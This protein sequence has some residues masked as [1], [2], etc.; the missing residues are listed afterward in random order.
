MTT[1][2]R[3][4]EYLSI[5]GFAI[6]LLVPSLDVVLKYFGLKG[7]AGY[8]VFGFTGLFLSYKFVWPLFRKLTEKQAIVL[9]ALTFAV[10]I[11]VV[12]YVYPIANSGGFG[13][14]SD[15]N[16]ALIIGATELIHGRY[17]FYQKTYLGNP[18]A[19]MPGALL[20]AAPFVFFG[21]YAVQN[22][23]WLAV[24]FTAVR[25]HLKSTVYALGLLWLILVFCPSVLQ[26]L[27]TGTDHISNTIYVLTAMWLMIKA[28]P[29][30]EASVLSKLL[31]TILLGVGLS[32][33]SNFIFLVPLLFSILVQ[34]SDWKTAFKYLTISGAACVLVTLPFWIYD[35]SGFTPFTVQA[36]KV[37]RFE[38]ILPFARI[39]VPLSGMLLAFALSLTK[40]NSDCHVFLRNCAIVQLFTVL[41]MSALASIHGGRLN[42]FFDHIGYGMFIL[43]FGVFAGWIILRE[44]DDTLGSSLTTVNPKA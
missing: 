1:K 25:N 3:A 24:F 17:P 7:V 16:D 19:P 36:D 40:M 22:I 34:N 31:P 9:A 44:R 37:T 13:G 41:F 18:I 30:S 23:F 15:A 11:A 28:I 38:E 5:L 39:V 26:N 14:G 12:G 32:S 35:P 10:M 27:V 42:L 43:F 33:R 21:L 8:L 6:F 2:N 20:L 29:N 4:G